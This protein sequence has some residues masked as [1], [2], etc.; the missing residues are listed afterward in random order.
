MT[1]AAVALLAAMGVSLT[2][3]VAMRVR[4][5]ALSKPLAPPRGSAA[6][7]VL[8]AFTV[9][10]APWAK[11]SASR[12]LPSY[13]AGIAYHLALFASIARLVVSLFGT[14][15]PSIADRA[16]AVVV[17]PGLACGVALLLKRCLDGRLRAISVPEDFFANAL[18]DA[19]LAAALATTLAP[20]ALP[21]FQSLGVLLFLYAPL[22]KLRHMVFLFTSRRA[23]GATFG[24][25]GVRPAPNPGGARR[26]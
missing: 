26:G 13:L 10:F 8:Y 21:V 7:G 11:E 6:A 1:P 24:R 16:I 5:G 20:R 14:P 25:R 18:V 19:V 3:F 23:L 4:M 17:A 22:G 9:A 2:V 15:L 12:H